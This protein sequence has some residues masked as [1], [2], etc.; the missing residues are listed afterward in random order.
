MAMYPVVSSITKTQDMALV[1]R[2]SLGDSTSSPLRP[3]STK[4]GTLNTTKVHRWP[5]GSSLGYQCVISNRK[6]LH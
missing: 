6:L 2:P 1:A 4:T 5:P 3:P